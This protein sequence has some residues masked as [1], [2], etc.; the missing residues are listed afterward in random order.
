MTR[1]V[2]DGPRGLART[3]VYIAV[4]VYCNVYFLALSSY[5]RIPINKFRVY[6]MMLKSEINQLSLAFRQ[7][8]T[9]S[10]IRLLRRLLT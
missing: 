3:A 9:S 4:V 8:N 10:I 2:H 1:D 5:R 6:K 7:E